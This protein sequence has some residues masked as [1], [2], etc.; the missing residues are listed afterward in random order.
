[1]IRPR[2]AASFCLILALALLA[3]LTA[4]A[5]TLPADIRTTT[6]S[7]AA[8]PAIQKFLDETVPQLADPNTTAA[9]RDS[10][11]AEVQTSANPAVEPSG[12][13]LDAYADLLNKSLMD[14]AKNNQPSVRLNVAV[15]A[16]RVAEKANN[17][18]L[19]PLV[20]QLL[21]DESQ[22][23]VLW[24]VKACKHL[25]SPLLTSAVGANDPLIPAFVAAAEKYANNGP[26]IQSVYEAL[27]NDAV[28]NAVTPPANWAK[29]APTIVK[30]M[31]DVLAKRIELYVKEGIPE[32]PMA[33]TI[34][35]NFLTS[36]NVFKS[37]TP[38]QQ[39]QTV[40]LCSDL[41]GAAGQRIASASTNQQYDM[42]E[43]LKKV[44]G[45]LTVLGQYVLNKGTQTD[46]AVKPLTQMM[47]STAPT[48]VATRAEAVYPQLVKISEFSKLNA[49]PK[50]Q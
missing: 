44:G 12:P 21:S 39:L 24:A 16:A 17:V 8:K 2:L 48:E 10:I 33:E 43:M 41:I 31:Q 3:P 38:Q 42:I 14:L 36:Q 50:I 46:A 25:I 26:M 22:A 47:V 15:T 4:G 18:R 30:L 19:A 29:Q 7:A 1:M 34:A 6:N 37:Q 49:P 28:Q 35:T 32:M 13:F 23:V 20:T 9:A 27:K 11:I 40:Q 5:A 45:G